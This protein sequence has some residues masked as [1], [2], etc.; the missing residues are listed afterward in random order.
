MINYNKFTV[1]ELRKVCKSRKI[2]IPRGFRKRDIVQRIEEEDCDGLDV[3]HE[4]VFEEKK[5]VKIEED[6]ICDE[7]E[8]WMEPL[9]DIVQEK[10]IVDMIFDYKQQME[11]VNEYGYVEVDEEFKKSVWYIS[12]DVCQDYTWSD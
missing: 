9:L 6:D 8:M 5:V 1:K 10:G 12:H 11:N 3:E 4:Y 7:E 2:K